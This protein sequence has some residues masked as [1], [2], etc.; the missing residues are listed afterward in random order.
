MQKNNT[1]IVLLAVVIFT[2]CRWPTLSGSESRDQIYFN[3]F[4]SE[5]DTQDWYGNGSFV[6]DDRAAPGGGKKSVKVSG[7][8][9]VPHAR[10]YLGKMEQ[11]GYLT[12][13]VWGRN[14]ELGG[15]VSLEVQG[16]LSAETS[17]FIT[18][19][20]WK[21]YQLPERLYVSPNSDVYLTMNSGGI[22]Y[23]AMLIDLIR[24]SFTEE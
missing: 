19:T 16:D 1:I 3:S 6:L 20:V 4:E 13:Q 24:V 12:V 8:C 9:V 15:L 10:Y 7:G 11:D 2:G 14:L 5:A 17:V 21:S 23:S 22:V 18:D